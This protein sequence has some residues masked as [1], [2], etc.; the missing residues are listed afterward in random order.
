MKEVICIEQGL[1]ELSE[2]ERLRAGVDRC[3]E[4]LDAAIS[5]IWEVRGLFRSQIPSLNSY[6]QTAYS[7]I[8]TIQKELQDHKARVLEEALGHDA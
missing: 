4:K 5:A 2:L 6:V 3:S 1:E 7:A 8:A